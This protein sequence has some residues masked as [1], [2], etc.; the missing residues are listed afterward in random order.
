MGLAD[1]RALR[2]RAVEAPLDAELLPRASGRRSTRSPARRGASSPRRACRRRRRSPHRRAC[3]C[4]MPAPTRA[5]VVPIRRSREHAGGFEAAHRQRYGFVV[6]DKALIV[7]AVSVEAVG[8]TEKLA[9]TRSGAAALRGTL[10]PKA[11]VRRFMRRRVADRPPVYRPRRACGR[12]SAST[13]PPSSSSRPPPPSSSPAGRRRWP[14]RG[15]LL[16]RRV[17]ALRRAAGDRH[18]LSIR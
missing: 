3:I 15:H 13:G 9:A 10:A 6:P 2:E 1:V 12:A 7:E 17:V 4:A 18:R 16:L 11:Q 8:A 5:L 14:T